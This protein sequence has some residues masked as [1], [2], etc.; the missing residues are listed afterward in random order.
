MA[1][2]PG[3]L[4]SIANSALDFYMNRGTVYKQ[5]IQSKPL[6]EFME[7]TKKMFPGGKGDISI[8]VK[9]D[10]GAGGVNDGV[11]GYTHNDT[12]AYYTP[13]NVMRAAYPWREHHIGITLTYT[14]LKIDGISVTDDAHPADS[15]SRHSKREQT[16]L[17]NI[18]EEKL[19]DLGEQYAR[20]M[21]GLM[22]GNG[23]A[24]PKALAGMR[25]II[26]DD[27]SQGTIGG[28]D[29]SK[30]KW[31][32]NRAYTA[33][34]EAAIAKDP[35]LA[36]FGGGPV[37]CSATSQEKSPLIQTLTREFR[38]LRRFGGNPKKFFAGAEFYAE[39]E[40]ELRSG[41]LFSMNGFT[42]NRDV[43]IGKIIWDGIEV[44]YDPSLDDLGYAKRAYVW[45]P[46][47][48]YLVAMDQE[49]AK[50]HSPPRPNDSY[51][52]FKSLTYT[53]QICAQQLNAALVI[54]IA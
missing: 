24:D 45:D 12:V 13:S 36:A 26:V 34:F 47:H 43:S 21:N 39:M 51:A 10:F 48:V 31:W 37:D 27:P 15:I 30:Y 35:S 17:A 19:F 5:S 11:K 14:E 50:P 29:R 8:G 54:D 40:A 25:A 28:L 32:R 18:F 4:Q 33:A 52:L 38:Q 23:T 44:V 22:W 3:E 20:T 9:G 53:G 49:W 16:M 7:S 6:L 1:F 46:N 42:G 41:G 2:T